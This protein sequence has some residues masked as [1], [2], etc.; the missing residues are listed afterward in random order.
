MVVSAALAQV[1]FDIIWSNSGVRSES[2]KHGPLVLGNTVCG[3]HAETAKEGMMIT[4]K[5]V[6]SI[7]VIDNCI[8]TDLI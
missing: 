2:S 4:S 6:K 5:E 8:S 7:Q 3:D 1:D